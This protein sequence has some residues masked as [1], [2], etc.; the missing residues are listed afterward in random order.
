MVEK[1]DI[2]SRMFVV[3]AGMASRRLLSAL[4]E[5]M[6]EV[7]NCISSVTQNPFISDGYHLI[8]GSRRVFSRQTCFS[9]LK[10]TQFLKL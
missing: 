1:E 9:S 2:Q 4:L 10:R 6:G 5:L 8:Y 7:C 3:G